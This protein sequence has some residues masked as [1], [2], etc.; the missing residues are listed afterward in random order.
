MVEIDLLTGRTHQIRVHFSSLSYPLVSDS[1]YLGKRLDKDLNWCPRIFL[2][3]KNLG[4][5]HPNLDW[6]E[7]ETNLTDDLLRCLEG[8]NK[9]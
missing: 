2:H 3:A 1:L 7:F 9:C 5:L 4:F 8:L 6:M